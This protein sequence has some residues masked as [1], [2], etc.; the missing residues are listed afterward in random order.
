[1]Y[2]IHLFLYGNWKFVHKNSIRDHK[3]DLIKH[4]TSNTKKANVLQL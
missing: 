4:V 3:P 1:M 2:T